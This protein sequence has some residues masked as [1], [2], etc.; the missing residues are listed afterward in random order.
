MCELFYFLI[1]KFYFYG[2]VTVQ[3][4]DQNSWLQRGKA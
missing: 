3:K 4:G 2:K 1:S